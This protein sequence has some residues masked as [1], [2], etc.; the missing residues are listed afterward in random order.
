M[1][2]TVVMPVYNEK[3]TLFE[4]IRRVLDA[5]LP[6]GIERELVLIDDCSR[7]GTPELY[8]LIPSKFP[9]ARIRVLRHQ[10]NQG[11]GAALRTGFAEAAGDIVLIQ[12]ADLEYDPREYARLLPPILDG[13]A[14]VVY[15]SRFAGGEEHRVLYFWHYLGNKFLTLM[16]NMFTN[17]NLTDMETCYK[18]FRGEVLRNIRLRSD[19]FGIEPEV[20]AKVARGR[21]RV[22]EVGI[23]YSGRSYEEGKKITWKDG[24]KAI[25]CIVRY[26]I[27]D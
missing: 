2:L 14:D 15:G 4:I 17:L 20:T 18:V 7:D 21:W 19:R 13:R 6:A 25:Y 26:A 5:P 1:L 9:N 3:D 12:D 16:S 8:P 24:V 10:V 27:A 22:F 23:S 11:K